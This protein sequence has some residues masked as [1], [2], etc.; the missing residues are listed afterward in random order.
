MLNFLSPRWLLTGVLLNRDARWMRPH[1]WRFGFLMLLFFGL[2]TGSQEISRRTAPGLDLLSILTWMSGMGLCFWAVIGVGSVF[3]DEWLGNNW[4]LLQLTGV[5]GF[6]LLLAKLIPTWMTAVSLLVLEIPCFLLC[7]TLGGLTRLH[8]AAV[9]WQLGWMFLVTSSLTVLSAAMTRNSWLIVLWAGCLLLGYQW[10]CWF[11]ELMIIAI[12]Q[13]GPPTQGVPTFPLANWPTE[14]RRIFSAAFSGPV[15]GW[16]ALIH[17]GTVAWALRSAAKF[18]KERMTASN[19]SPPLEETPPEGEVHQ[20]DVPVWRPSGPL[21]R[22]TGNAIEWKDFHFT[23][24]G[25]DMLRGKWIMISVGAAVFTLLVLPLLLAASPGGDALPCIFLF[26]VFLV[27]APMASLVHLANRLWVQEIRER[28]L[29]GLLILPLSAREIV[30]AKLRAFARMC[31]PEAVLYFLQLLVMIVLSHQTGA[32]HIA[33]LFVA[34]L[35]SIP[36]VVCTDAA[37]RLVPTGLS[38]LGS[39]TLLAGMTLGAWIFS[40]LVAGLI[41]PVAGLIV[42]AVLVPFLCSAAIT[43]AADALGNPTTELVN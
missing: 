42:F 4:E 11:F 12:V 21:P 43:I 33:Q 7:I 36:L 20:S 27:V 39:R 10:L 18:L 37:W 28:T 31:V 32:W 40:G 22:I 34:M 2:W 5:S 6:D 19:D 13:G 29:E 14:F 17:A 26:V 25:N 9:V 3:R 24:G 15:I 30:L 8:V 1:A 41:D 23:L 38:G 16:T 35:L